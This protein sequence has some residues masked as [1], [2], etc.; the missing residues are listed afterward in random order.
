M[1]LGKTVELLQRKTRTDNAQTDTLRAFL[2]V[3]N[4]LT[5]MCM[6]AAFGLRD[7]LMPWSATSLLIELHNNPQLAS[8]YQVEV[9]DTKV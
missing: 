6:L 3:G 5:L 7:Q 9:G 4:D 8:G 1:L 2:H